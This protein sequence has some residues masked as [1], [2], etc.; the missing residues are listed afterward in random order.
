MEHRKIHVDAAPIVLGTG[1]ERIVDLGPEFEIGT[2]RH[3]PVTIGLPGDRADVAATGQ[4][5]N[6]RRRAR[7][8][9][10]RAIEVEAARLIAA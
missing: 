9:Q 8:E 5:W 7:P 2:R 1:F 4:R 6:C 3:D 10:G